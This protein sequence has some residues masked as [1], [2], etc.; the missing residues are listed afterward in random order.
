MTIQKLF[1]PVVKLVTV[2]RV[3]TLA[4]TNS[5]LI[6][7]LDVNNANLNGLLSKWPI[8]QPFGFVS[9]QPTQVC[10]LNKVIYDLKQAPKAWFELLTKSLVLFG[11][12]TSKC[13]P[14][15]FIHTQSG[16]RSY[17]LIYIDDIIV[18]GSSA[19]RVTELIAKLNAE[20]ALKQLRDLDYFL[21]IEIK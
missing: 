16:H 20:F 10:K 5:W 11:F 2:R 15:L 14:S 8:E 3:L 4:I 18:T 17:L 21:G 7:Q 6:E 9:A 19:Q 13:D 12:R 1:S